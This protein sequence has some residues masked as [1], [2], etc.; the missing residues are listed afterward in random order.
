M[1]SGT[2]AVDIT[3]KNTKSKEKT[4]T[5]IGGSPCLS[6]SRRRDA[7]ANCD[8]RSDCTHIGTNKQN[9]FVMLKKDRNGKISNSDSMKIQRYSPITSR[10][11]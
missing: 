5:C 6:F 1:R 3:L 9:E 2:V 11:R 8:N 4:F 7:E 10:S